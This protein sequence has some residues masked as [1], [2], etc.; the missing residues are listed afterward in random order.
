MGDKII[1]KA[2]KV[3]LQLFYKPRTTDKYGGAAIFHRKS[4][5]IVPD[6]I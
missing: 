3:K 4:H 6:L 5:K 1:I 2:G